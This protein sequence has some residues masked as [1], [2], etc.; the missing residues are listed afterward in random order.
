MDELKRI[1]DRV[2]IMRD[3]EYVD[4]VP[5]A[6]TPISTIITKMVGREVKDEPL[7]V[8]DTSKNPIALEVK[9]LR[10]GR[11]IKDVSFTLRQGEIL[12]FAD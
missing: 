6:D 10:R 8:P 3:G 7:Q 4:T 1:A 9:G 2:T 12:G 5:A 11:E